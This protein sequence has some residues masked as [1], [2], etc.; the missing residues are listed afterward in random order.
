[1]FH[2]IMSS[3][4]DML[5]SVPPVRF[6]MGFV[7]AR[8]RPLWAALWLAVIAYVLSRAMN[9][10]ALRRALIRLMEEPATPGVPPGRGGKGG[11]SLAQDEA[12]DEPRER[13]RVLKPTRQR[14]LTPSQASAP[15]T[16]G[17]APPGATPPGGARL[18]LPVIALALAFG[19]LAVA[20]TSL[21]LPKGSPGPG[22]SAST[23]GV[24]TTAAADTGL[25]VRWRSG[26]KD[27]DDCIATFEVTR[28][29]GTRAQFVAFV[30]DTTGAVMARDSARVT[31]AVR[32]LLVE[33]R[34]RHVDCEEIDDWQLQVT[35]PKARGN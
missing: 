21:F 28:G 16:P 30:M 20:I 17:A 14:Q 1:V 29:N 33:L 24:D 23:Q 2:D 9:Q 35:T 31:S 5:Y 8:W 7:D 34:F 18:P 13:S 26:R 15:P 19:V 27:D 6:V 3:I 22:A 25:D 10:L 11:D 32:G 12:D 4:V